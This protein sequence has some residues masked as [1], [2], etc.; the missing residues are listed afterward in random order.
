MCS[1]LYS[2]SQTIEI[3]LILFALAITLSTWWPSNLMTPPNRSPES[4]LTAPGLTI[5]VVA[6]SVPSLAV[7]ALIRADVG[8]QNAHSHS[9]SGHYHFINIDIKDLRFSLPPT[10]SFSRVCPSICTSLCVSK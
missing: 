8:Q 10:T 7:R 1:C 3:L 4:W 5:V 6:W 9:R 2:N